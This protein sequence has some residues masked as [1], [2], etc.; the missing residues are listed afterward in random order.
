VPYLRARQGHVSVLI[1]INAKQRGGTDSKQRGNCVGCNTY[2][3]REHL[4]ISSESAYCSQQTALRQRCLRLH[5]CA[6]QKPSEPALQSQWQQANNIRPIFLTEGVCSK[7]RTWLLKMTAPIKQVM[8]KKK[9]KKK[10]CWL[11]ISIADSWMR[12]FSPYVMTFWEMTN[13]N[14]VKHW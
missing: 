11:V 14:E 4:F 7:K 13:W 8:A 10:K 12:F 2:S 3:T 5:T 6:P 1:W 9:K